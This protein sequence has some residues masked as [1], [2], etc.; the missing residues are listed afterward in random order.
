MSGRASLK[1][2]VA[3]PKVHTITTSVPKVTSQQNPQLSYDSHQRVSHC[4]TGNNDKV[5][6][7][8]ITIRLNITRRIAIRSILLSASDLL[9]NNLSLS[10]ETQSSTTFYLQT[11]F[12]AVC[13]M[14][15]LLCIL[16]STLRQMWRASGMA[17]CQHL[18]TGYIFTQQFYKQ[19][20][21]WVL[22]LTHCT[23]THH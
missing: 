3:L 20:K 21:H 5:T 10:G 17:G 23:T 14:K 6:L 11:A 7:N 8:I 18:H 4:F 2:S 12:K 1:G 19:T 22:N 9:S 13:H 16:Y 15:P